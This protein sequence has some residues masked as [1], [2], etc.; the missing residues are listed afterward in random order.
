MFVLNS[1][2]TIGA[3]RL[4]PY[5]VQVQ[6]SMMSY[7]DRATV[8]L[9]A[10][11]RLTQA[12]Q[13]VTQIETARQFKQG[14]RV[15]I[16]LGYNGSLK[17]EF[18]GFVS[19]VNFSQPVEVECEGYSYQLRK[20]T[21][22][23]KKTFKKAQ[24]KEILAFL[25]KDTDIQLATNIPPFEVEKF[26]VDGSCGTEYL[27]ILKKKSEDTLLF[28]FKGRILFA[29]MMYLQ[30]ADPTLKSIAPDVTVK[31]RLGWNVIKDN[32][33]KLRD[34]QNENVTV[35]FIGEK[36]DGTRVTTVINGHKRTKDNI[37]RTTAIAGTTGETKVFK[38]HDVNDKESLQLMGNAKQE[39]LSYKGYEGKIT[40][41]LQPYCE[42][43]CVAE[44]ED[45]KFPE[46]SGKYLVVSVEVN[47]GM[48]G[49]RRSVEIGKKIYD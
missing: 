16:R 11:A 9:P 41:F 19:R 31:Y 32:D 38:T 49:A 25:V 29:G 37:S 45:R 36:K 20:K 48:S 39:T 44:I 14:D 47:Y 15:V 2:I 26:V 18:E 40:A 7:R 34:P 27:E 21:N 5:Q 10:T 24:L 28:F 17:N 43:N 3:Y 35:N 6:R 13:K 33:L 22:Y 23:E 8:K 4:K 1:D 12:G 42:P 30:A 46:R